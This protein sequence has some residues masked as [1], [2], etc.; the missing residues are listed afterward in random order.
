MPTQPKWM[1]LF[2]HREMYRNVAGWYLSPSSP[3]P[4][5]VRKSDDPERCPTSAYPGYIDSPFG[6][7]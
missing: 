6:S 2:K 1:L 5:V 4:N 3:W 7:L